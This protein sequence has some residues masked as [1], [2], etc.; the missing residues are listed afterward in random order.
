MKKDEKN[1]GC[2]VS[3]SSEP[4]ESEPKKTSAES[5]IEDDIH[6]EKTELNIA[7]Q[8]TIVP[9]IKN[10]YKLLNF[11]FTTRSDILR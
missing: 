8:N 2:G 9:T 5:K 4:Q 10:N 11:E 7:P 3:S 1:M 6:Q